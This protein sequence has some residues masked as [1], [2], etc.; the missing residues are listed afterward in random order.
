MD[1]LSLNEVGRLAEL[2]TIIEQGIQTFIEVGNALLEIRDSRLYRQEYTTFEEY[3]QKR[4]DL[5]RRRAY[6]L[7]EAAETVSTLNVQNFAHR[8]NESQARA[9]AQIEEPEARRE[10]W[11]KAVET[12]PDGKI[13]AR[14]VETVVKGFQAVKAQPDHFTCPRCGK[15]TAKVNGGA[16]CLNESCGAIWPTRAE[17][18][19]E[20]DDW[21]RSPL[22]VDFSGIPTPQIE[23]DLAA[24]ISA[25]YGDGPMARRMRGE[26][27]HR[28]ASP[29]GE[30][31]NLFHL[32]ATLKTELAELVDT[33]PA[34]QLSTLA[35]WL[36]E[37][38]QKLATTTN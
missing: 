36:A 6:Q 27:E 7:I 30:P 25:G 12:A 33:L 35:A 5:K 10:V 29:N 19:A 17:Y 22:T 18:E 37:A 21:G 34:E 15:R 16:I 24:I 11:Q 28:E 38:R 23:R 2:E 20:L 32:R 26:L 8:P 9:L 4:W 14:H 31:A 1:S 3:C 13:T